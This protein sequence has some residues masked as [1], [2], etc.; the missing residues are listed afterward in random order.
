MNDK[1]HRSPVDD[2]DLMLVGIGYTLA[3]GKLFCDFAEFQRYAEGLMGE[4][5]LTHQFADEKLWDLMRESFE[6]RA[7]VAFS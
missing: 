2:R 5:L 1:P 7:R 6:A 4:P 3:S